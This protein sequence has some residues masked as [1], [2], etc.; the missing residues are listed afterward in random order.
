MELYRLRNYVELALEMVADTPTIRAAEVCASWGGHQL[1]QVQHDTER[2]SDDVRALHTH[3]TGGLSF[4]VVLAGGEGR[5]VGFAMTDDELTP[6]SL[7][8]ALERA[9]HSAMVEPRTLAF[10]RPL[11]DTPPPMSLYDP[12][13]LDLPEDDVKQAAGEV[14]D[15]ALTTLQE[16]G[17]VQQLRVRGAVRSQYEHL[18]VGNTEGL[19]ASDTTTGL[20]ATMTVHLLQAQSRGYGS[21]VTTHRGDFVPYD[22]GVEAAQQALRAQGSIVVP[23][24]DYEVVFGP[25]AVAAL[26]QDVLLPA[27]SLD[28]V[29]AGTSPFATQRGQ[30]IA[31]PLL[32]M[33]DNGRL[34]GLLGSRLMTGDGLPTSLTTLI[35]HG[36]LVGFL[37][38]AYHAQHLWEH[39]GAVGPRHGLRH[40]TTGQSF[41]MRPGIFPTNITFSSPEMVPLDDLLAPIVHG[42]YLG[43]LWHLT[44]PEGLQTGSCTGLIVGPSFVIRHGKLVEPVRPGTLRLQDNVLHVLQ[45]LTGLSTTEQPVVLATRQSLVLAPEWRCSQV[46]VVASH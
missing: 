8:E 12:Q 17:V 44:A 25:R 16:A 18:V 36:R 30:L 9:R 1:V 38:D 2:P 11:D 40:T 20:L 13:V 6:E 23:G 37:A 46:H 42:L 26:L 5:T 34:P 27:L 32:T 7:R 39:I 15:G 10:P 3:T 43:D 35:E 14:M 29:A 21:Q 31:S 41:S 45:R 22:A 19:L 28:T 4:L 33:A 24:D